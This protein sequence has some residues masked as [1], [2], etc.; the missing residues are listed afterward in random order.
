MKNCGN[1]IPEVTLRLAKERCIKGTG[2]V[3][4]TPAAVVEVLR[5]VVGRDAAQESF[6][7][8]YLSASNEVLATQRIVLGGLDQVAVDPK[9]LFAGALLAGARAMIVG[10][11]HPSGDT[12]PSAADDSMT[13]SLIESGK[14]LT[15]R[16]LDHIIFSD[17][18]EF[19][20]VQHGRLK[21]S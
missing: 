14:L 19:S 17:N 15:I 18:A 3:V 11:N 10:H 6:V 7:A 16:L 2:T 20:Y 13:Q 5:K 12:Q 9:V 1:A 4:R 8:V 21:F